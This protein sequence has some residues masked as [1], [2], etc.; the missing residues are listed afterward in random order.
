MTIVLR[1]V[2]MV[3][4]AELAAN[5]SGYIVKKIIKAYM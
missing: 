4:L 1:K 3:V 5:A 2:A